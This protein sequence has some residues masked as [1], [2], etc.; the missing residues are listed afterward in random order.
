MF[1]VSLVDRDLK[2]V[3]C[4]VFS[5][6]VVFKVMVFYGRAEMPP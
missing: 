6:C 2:T 3:I 4:A 5:A 1:P